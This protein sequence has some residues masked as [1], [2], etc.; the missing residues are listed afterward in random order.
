MRQRVLRTLVEYGL[1][2]VLMMLLFLVS[3][4][5][6]IRLFTLGSPSIPVSLILLILP[7]LAVV[8]FS[9]RIHRVLEPAVSDTFM[10]EPEDSPSPGDADTPEADS[11]DDGAL[12]PSARPE[13]AD[14]SLES[15]VN[16]LITS[17]IE[18]TPEHTPEHMPERGE[19]SQLMRE[20][21]ELAEGN[22]ETSIPPDLPDTTEE[23]R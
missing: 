9:F 4:P 1:A 8:V 16:P 12:P 21:S 11:F 7:A 3:L 2:S 20:D 18:H 17:T 22:A 6:V 10:A 23:D 13:D 14:A 19:L 5:L 15:L